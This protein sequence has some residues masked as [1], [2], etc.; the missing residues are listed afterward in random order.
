MRKRVD[1]EGVCPYRRRVGKKSRR[2]KPDREAIAASKEDERVA[3]EAA[4]AVRARRGR[5][6]AIG[7]PVVTVVLAAIVYL[8][9]EHRAG[10]ALV[11][12]SGLAFWIP[13]LLGSVGA[14]V[15]PRDA[16]R[17][18]SIDFGNRRD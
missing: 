6:L 16:A 8:A 10:T 15:P 17:S 13:V 4:L 2:Q 7:I 5:A 1:C 18:G 3:A 12:V 11:A 14:K 9:F